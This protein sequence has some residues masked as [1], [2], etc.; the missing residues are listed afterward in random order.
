MYRAR[1]THTRYTVIFV[2]SYF[3]SLYL[4]LVFH[5]GEERELSS[6]L[7][8]R[9]RLCSLAMENFPLCDSLQFDFR[10]F[11][12]LFPFHISFCAVC[13]QYHWHIY[14]INRHCRI[15]WL[16]ENKNN[17][18]T[19]ESNTILVLFHILFNLFCHFSLLF[20]LISMIIGSIG[21][22]DSAVTIF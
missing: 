22:F 20:R 10:S 8:F 3:C 7:Y 2:D 17:R 13:D 16:N 12:F 1:H 18:K 9:I 11:F 4:L 21:K 19:L 15:R 5:K 6:I 14:F